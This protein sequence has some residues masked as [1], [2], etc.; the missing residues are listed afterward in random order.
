MNH[1]LAIAGETGPITFGFL[2]GTIVAAI[3][4]LALIVFAI[5][6]TKANRFDRYVGGVL[7]A[8]LVVAGIWLAASWPLKYDYHHWVET[9]GV[10]KSV[11]TRL[12]TTGSGDSKGIGQKYVFRFEDGRLRAV[13]DTAA[14]VVKEG[15]VVKLRCKRAFEFGVPQSS[16]GW[17]CKWAGAR[18]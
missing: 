1:I 6:L 10:V 7:G 8:A 15:D 16:N 3:I 17:D 12:V 18:D 11:G 2:F 4:V 13:N 5:I 9:S 14:A